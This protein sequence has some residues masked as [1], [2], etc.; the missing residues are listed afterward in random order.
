MQKQYHGVIIEDDSRLSRH[1]RR[2]SVSYILDNKQQ[3]APHKLTSFARSIDDK[4][5]IYPEKTT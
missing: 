4:I 2:Y 3:P 1:G 5:V